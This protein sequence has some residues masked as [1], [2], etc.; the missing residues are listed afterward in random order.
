MIRRPP[1]STPLYSSAASD[2]YKR[3]LLWLLRAT[4]FLEWFLVSTFYIFFDNMTGQLYC[5]ADKV[6]TKYCYGLFT[7]SKAIIIQRFS[8]FPV[9]TN[10]VPSQSTISI[11]L[12]FSVARYNCPF[13]AGHPSFP[14][15]LSAISFK[16]GIPSTHSYSF[17]TCVE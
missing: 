6:G 9:G 7:F 17:S 13:K 15:H 8:F 14:S 2:V 3:Q 10:F 16:A 4:P 11:S 12:N 1:R 5:F